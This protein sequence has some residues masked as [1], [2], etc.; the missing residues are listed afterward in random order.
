MG[1]W[2]YGGKTM[3]IRLIVILVEPD[4]LINRHFMAFDDTS[5]SSSWK[6]QM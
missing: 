3:G 1:G 6:V 5:G 4:R 2:E